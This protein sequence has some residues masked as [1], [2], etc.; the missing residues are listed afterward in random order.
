MGKHVETILTQRKHTIVGRVDPVCGD[1]PEITREPAS[2]AEVAIE[3]SIPKVAIANME[4]YAQF[5]LNAVM[6]TT[7]WYEQLEK[8]K[9]LISQSGIGLVY[10]SNFSIG[11]HLF[12]RLVE[13]AAQIVDG[14]FCR[15]ALNF[16]SCLEFCLTTGT[17]VEAMA[18]KIIRQWD[19]WY[20]RDSP[21]LCTRAMQKGITS[22]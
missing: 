4:L 22:S 5:G 9:A 19:S 21:K 18:A 1:Y 13:K 11:A 14:I 15:T 12:F 17:P 2:R 16:K 3:F 10:G 8:V 20:N 6:A 7:G